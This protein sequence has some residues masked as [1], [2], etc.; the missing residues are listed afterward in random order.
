MAEWRVTMRRNRETIARNRR[1]LERLLTGRLRGAASC[2]LPGEGRG[3][4]ASPQA[5]RPT[6]PHRPTRRS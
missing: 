3:A 1:A 4:G 6:P 2:G 5:A